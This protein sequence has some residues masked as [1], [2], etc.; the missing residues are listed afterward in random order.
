M[1]RI[2]SLRPGFRRGTDK[3]VPE[4]LNS[5][6]PA[7]LFDGVQSAASAADNALARVHAHARERTAVPR[8]PVRRHS[9]RAHHC[10]AG[11]WRRTTRQETQQIVRA[12]K[13]YDREGRQPG[14]RSGPL[15]GIAIELIELLA[16]LVDFR[17]GRLDP[18]IDTIM[19][20]LRRSRGA[21][22]SAL[23]ALRDHGFLD[24]MRRYVHTGNEGRGPQVQQTSNAYRLSLPERARALLGR[25]GKAVPLPLDVEQAIKQ[26]ESML[27]SHQAQLSLEE[28]PAFLH[29]D[30]ALSKSLA[31]LGTLIGRK[32][33]SIKQT[34]S[35]PISISK[36]EKIG[37]QP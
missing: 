9:Y 6:Y 31:A 24:W 22:V 13:R 27:A 17:S 4:T 26:R 35:P 15:G 30:T 7:T 8:T 29:G 14:T 18:S 12:A 5:T 20:M 37:G 10:E 28:L 34:E 2:D 11:I 16:N 1:E 23:K 19:R 25:F 36:S 3:R 32:R 21:V 33:E